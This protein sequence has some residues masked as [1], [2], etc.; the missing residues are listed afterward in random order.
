VFNVADAELV[1]G[2]LGLAVAR[3]KWAP[4]P[5]RNPAKAS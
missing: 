3:T 4:A 1:I 5:G 2:V